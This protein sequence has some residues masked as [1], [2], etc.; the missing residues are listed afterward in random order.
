MPA[1]L[2]STAASAFSDVSGDPAEKQIEALRQS[3]VVSGVNHDL[4]APKESITAAQGVQMIVNGLELSL[5][6]Y[7]FIKAPQAS[8]SF[9][10]IPNDAWYAEAFVIAHVNGLPLARDI[11]PDAPLTREQFVQLVVAAVNTTGD[12]PVT[13]SYERIGDE[14]EVGED[15]MGAVQTALKLKIVSLDAADNFRPKAVTTRSE[16]ASMVH[17][18]ITFV[19][20]HKDVAAKPEPPVEQNGEVTMSSEKVNDQINRITV[21]WGEM[22]NPGY[23]LTVDRIEFGTNGEAVIVYSTH[24]PDPDRM[25][26]Q[27]ITEAKTS[28]YLGSEFKPVLR[29]AKDS[30][31]PQVIT[32]AIPAK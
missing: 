31:V 23:R 24:K 7:Q 12:Y 14:K 22:P 11:D 17:A 30:S 26:P 8:D 32:P 2:W 25:Y 9:T 29:A 28:V 3:G 18:A 6:K 4:F 21:T 10:N 13:L 1:L 16:A 19:Q 20:E 5:A 27:V 15:F